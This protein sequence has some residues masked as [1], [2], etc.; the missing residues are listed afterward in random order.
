MI[1]RIYLSNQ[2][3]KKKKRDTQSHEKSLTRFDCWYKCTDSKNFLLYEICQSNNIS[4]LFTIIMENFIANIFNRWII[5]SVW[6]NLDWFK[7]FQKTES[8]FELLLLVVS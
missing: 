3:K 1:P 6:E 2:K 5:I 7:L 8:I 4:L